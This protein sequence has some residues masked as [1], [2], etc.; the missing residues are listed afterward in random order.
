[1][2]LKCRLKVKAVDNLTVGRYFAALGA[3]WLGFCFDESSPN[4]V[5]PQTV[6]EIIP[7]LAGPQMVAEFGA[8]QADAIHQ[9]CNELSIKRIETSLAI[10][11]GLAAASYEQIF[12]RMKLEDFKKLHDTA[13]AIRAS[14]HATTIFILDLE[15]SLNHKS[16]LDEQSCE[17]L[18]SLCKEQQVLISIKPSIELADYL[19][20]NVAPLGLEISAGKEQ[21]TGLRAFEDVD[22][23][24]EWLELD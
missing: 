7:W 21:A 15:E 5:S 3:E 12:Q 11:E 13:S 24:M 8:Q 17:L 14:K 20:E 19:L 22:P 23:L 18:A 1:M 2:S 6:S 16:D 10:G 9:I 4:F